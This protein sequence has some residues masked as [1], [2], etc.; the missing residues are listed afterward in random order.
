MPCYDPRDN[1][2][3]VYE[4][5]HDPHF[6]EEAKRLSIRCKE[7]TNLLCQ[8]GR[9]RHNNTNI[10]YEVIAWWDN[11]CKLDKSRGEPW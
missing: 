11:H 8:A 9:A 3:V 2:R 7:L 4:K 5:G 6:A 10:P 1:T